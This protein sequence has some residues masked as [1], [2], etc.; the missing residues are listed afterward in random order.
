MGERRIDGIA[1]GWAGEH[2]MLKKEGGQRE[3]KGW[4][5]GERGSRIL[6][7]VATAYAITKV[8]LPVRILVSVWGTPWFAR[9]FIGRV[10]G[11]FGR[12]GRKA[13]SSGSGAAGTGATAGGAVDKAGKNL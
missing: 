2:P 13:A 1:D 11:L 5:V 4:R 12:G 6:V 9:T 7:E 10:G 3:G 8:L